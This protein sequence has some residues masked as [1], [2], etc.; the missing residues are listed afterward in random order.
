[1]ILTLDRVLEDQTQVIKMGSAMSAVCKPKKIGDFNVAPTHE[2]SSSKQ[3]NEDAFRVQ[4]LIDT[5]GF[6]FVFKATRTTT[7]ATYALKVQPMQFMTRLT[8]AG[9]TRSVNKRSLHIE[10]N[11]LVT[12]R[13]HPFIVSLEYAFC[14]QLYAVLAMEYI[15]G[16]W[17][18]VEHCFNSPSRFNRCANIR[19]HFI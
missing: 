19:R 3:I 6:G 10:R 11:T 1:M 14:T 12:L 4:H 7:K 17:G 2:H 16:K 9:G 18:S 13:G 5:G 15:P 8:R